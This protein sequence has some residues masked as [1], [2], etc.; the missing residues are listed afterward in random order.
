MKTGGVPTNRWWW[1]PGISALVVIVALVGLPLLALLRFADFDQLFSPFS[2]P[3]LRRVITF[4]WYQ[5]ALSTLLSVGLAVPVARSLSRR[6]NFPGRELLLKLFSVSLIVPT[7]V[8]VFGIV[9][10]YGRSGWLNTVLAEFGFPAIASIY[11]LFGIL[12]AHV[13]FNLPLAV[14]IILQALDSVPQSNWKLAAQLGMSRWQRFKLLE[15]HVL[16]LQ[17][18]GL[19]LLIFTLC[20]TSFAIVMT[21][22]GGPKAT[23]IEVAIY[24]A[25]R[26]DFDLGSAVTLATLQF[27]FCALLMLI[28][29]MFQ[30]TDP[31]VSFA[32]VSAQRFESDSRF[33]K[34]LDAVSIGIAFLLV[35]LPLGA[36][37]LSAMNPVL[38][39]VLSLQSTTQAIFN[40]LW[41]AVLSG[42]LATVLGLCLIFSARHLS[43]RLQ[44]HL[45]SRALEMA[46]LVILIIPPIV[47]GTGLF[48][49]LRPYADV[50]SIA[51]VLVVLVNALMGLPFVLKVVAVPASQ[52]LMKHDRLCASLGMSGL[53]R[54]RLVEWPVLR[55]PIGLAMAIATALSAGDLTVIALFGS[56]RMTTLPYLL[57]QRIGSYRMLE[58]SATALILLVVCIGLFWITERLIGGRHASS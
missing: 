21:L 41:V 58:G 57:Y 6:S 19:C 53:Q 27:A 4:S 32:V 3:W 22:G 52:N 2:D 18:P 42:T 8:A 56:E 31:L 24:Q 34:A 37:A 50:F 43:V 11:G 46:G 35:L 28:A 14:R 17:L 48:L 40:T 45:G 26:F 39:K 20:F 54:M 55:K 7:I 30:R 5:A 16:K 51:L 9:A 49:W 33:L 10:V 29:A 13:F 47:L 1:V 12:L 23:T 25:L 38:L 15:W 44:L 36:I